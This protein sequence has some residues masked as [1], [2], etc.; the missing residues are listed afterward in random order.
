MPSVGIELK[1]PGLRTQCTAA[2]LRRLLVQRQ[3]FSILKIYLYCNLQKKIHAFYDDLLI[4]SLQDSATEVKRLCVRTKMTV[5][6]RVKYIHAFCM[7]QTSDSQF[8]RPVAEQK[9]EINYSR[10]AKGH[11]E[12]KYLHFEL[13]VILSMK[14][15]TFH[16]IVII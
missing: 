1:I 9:S 10:Y 8:A 4:P 7:T 6:Q 3:N 5:N 16:V 13:L 14:A 2:E 15:S 11:S 12:Q